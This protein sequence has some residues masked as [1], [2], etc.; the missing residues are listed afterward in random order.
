MSLCVNERSIGCSVVVAGKRA[1]RIRVAKVSGKCSGGLYLFV[2]SV[3]WTSKTEWFLGCLFQN[4]KISYMNA[5]FITSPVSV[6][7]VSL[8]SKLCFCQYPLQD[9]SETSKCQTDSPNTGWLLTMTLIKIVSYTGLLSFSIKVITKANNTLNSIS[10]S[11]V[12]TEVIQSVQGME[13]LLGRETH[14]TRKVAKKRHMLYGFVNLQTAKN[15]L[16]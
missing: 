8:N 6:C 4:S 11:S 14:T 2:F 9:M 1:L 5:Y 10:S 16:A 13:Y 7:H 12:C 3:W 15:M